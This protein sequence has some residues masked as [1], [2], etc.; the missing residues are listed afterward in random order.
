MKK[1]ANVNNYNTYGTK[2]KVR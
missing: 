1:E 2:Q